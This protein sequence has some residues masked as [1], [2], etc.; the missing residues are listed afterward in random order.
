MGSA[1][2]KGTT[3]VVAQTFPRL[4]PKAVLLTVRSEPHPFPTGSL[5]QPTSDVQGPS[6]SVSLGHRPSHRRQVERGQSSPDNLQLHERFH[7]HDEG[8]EIAMVLNKDTLARATDANVTHECT[9]RRARE[10]VATLEVRCTLRR[11]RQGTPVTVTPATS[12]WHTIVGKEGNTVVVCF[13]DPCMRA[14]SA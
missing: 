7:F 2:V 8:D 12:H 14:M 11:P 9:H 4:L 3:T 5:D 6:V 1:F 10:V 13:D